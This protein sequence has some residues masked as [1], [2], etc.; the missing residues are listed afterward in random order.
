VTP[1]RRRRSTN[2]KKWKI[3]RIA[4]EVR[5]QIGNTKVSSNVQNV[6]V[7]AQD[8]I[9]TEA[10]RS[11]GHRAKKSE[12]KKDYVSFLFRIATYQGEWIMKTY[13]GTFLLTVAWLAFATSNAIAAGGAG[14]GGAGTAEA[15]AGAG[16]TAGVSGSAGASGKTS[17]TNGASASENKPSANDGPGAGGSVPMPPSNALQNQPNSSPSSSA[18]TNTGT[19]GG[20]SSSGNVPMPPTNALQNQPNSSSSRQQFGT[21][22]IAPNNNNA[23][24][25]TPNGTVLGAGGGVEINVDPSLRRFNDGAEGN[26]GLNNSDAQRNRQERDALRN[27]REN[28]DVQNGQNRQSNPNS[29]R[30]VRNNGEWW[31]WTPGDYWMYYRDNQWYRFDTNAY[32]PNNYRTG[33]RGIPDNGSS[34]IYYDDNRQQYRRDYSPDRRALRNPGNDGAGTR[35]GNAIGNTIRGAIDGEPNAR[36]NAESGGATPDKQ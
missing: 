23:H 6:E 33:Y 31:Y 29:W 30:F 17:A 4:T 21:P 10:N 9:P 22:Q 36:A 1:R 12:R 20:A 7:I 27:E 2:P 11:N 13:K 32:Q 25:N 24:V 19:P 16:G 14:A 35:L 26:G 34:G 3:P 5:K 8:E 18:N 28:Q 15:S